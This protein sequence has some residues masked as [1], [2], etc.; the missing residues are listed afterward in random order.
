MESC[1]LLCKVC[2]GVMLNNRISLKVALL[3]EYMHNVK[4]SASFTEI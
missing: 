3:V 2:S 4:D 1:T